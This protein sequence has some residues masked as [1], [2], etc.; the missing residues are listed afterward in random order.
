MSTEH[1]QYSTE[2]QS[3]VNRRYAEAH[4]LK[5]IRTYADSGR[6][7]LSLRTRNALQQ[8]I[9]EVQSKK[10]DFEWGFRGKVNA[11]PG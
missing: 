1:Q 4:G 2:N 11:I 9:R 7:G 10:P 5:I 6:S 8:L 3:D